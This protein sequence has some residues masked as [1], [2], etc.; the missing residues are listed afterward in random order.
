MRYRSL[1]RPDRGLAGEPAWLLS[2]LIHMAL[3]LAV[4]LA[5]RVVPKGAT[6][7]PTRT[8]GIVLKSASQ[9]GTIDEGQEDRNDGQTAAAAE[10]VASVSDR[11]LLAAL[12]DQDSIPDPTD[13][14]PAKM[15]VIGPGAAAA[16]SGGVA[17]DP[18]RGGGGQPTGVRGGKARVG[19]FGLVGE[20]RK[21]V[22]VF[23][24]STSMEEGGRLAAAKAEL[25][26]SLDAL[27][28]THQFQIV[29]FNHNR[30]VFD[31]S[32]GQRRIP[33]ATDRTKRLAA[34]FVGSIVAAGGTNRSDALG[35][36]VGM[37][38]DVIF[39]LT[40]DDDPMSAGEL[41]QIRI[42]NRG[43]CAIHAIEFGIGPG[44]GDE[45]FL[46]RLARQNG[47]DYVYVNAS[48]LSAR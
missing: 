29:F 5:M 37:R 11:A 40:D 36:A 19:V 17:G 33:F 4:G 39:F 31:L 13:S 35:F 47:G 32:G 41:D 34:G 18:T 7:E 21:F 10:T 23:D 25:V 42:K 24:R 20:G 22:Y 8:V 27:A 2:G 46:V 3:I 48:A 16:Q 6:E 12:P 44:A 28:S 43:V 1:S 15:D 14:L 45:N 26:R 38:P 9:D 30:R